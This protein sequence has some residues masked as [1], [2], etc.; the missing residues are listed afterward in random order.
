LGCGCLQGS[1]L[2]LKLPDLTGEFG[3]VQRSGGTRC[4]CRGRPD[5]RNQLLPVGLHRAQPA[6]NRREA[7]IDVS[8]RK[9]NFSIELKNALDSPRDTP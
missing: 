4:R 5:F 2:F 7:L 8:E 1:H 3:G 9:F 6:V